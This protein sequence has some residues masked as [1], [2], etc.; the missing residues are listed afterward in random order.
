MP[1]DIA[2]YLAH[3]CIECRLLVREC[4]ARWSPTHCAHLVRMG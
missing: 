4:A 3:L 2:P 1:E